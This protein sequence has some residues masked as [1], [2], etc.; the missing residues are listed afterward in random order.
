MLKKFTSSHGLCR[1]KRETREKGTI[2]SSKIGV[3]C[4]ENLEFRTSNP[5]PSRS[6]ILT[7]RVLSFQTY[8]RLDCRRTGIGFPHPAK[9]R[10][11]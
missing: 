10:I 11:G 7:G 1:V 5:R 8:R 3:Q 9:N 2:R 4:S 6:V